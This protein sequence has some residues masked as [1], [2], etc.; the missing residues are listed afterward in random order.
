MKDH[1]KVRCEASGNYTENWIQGFPWV[2]QQILKLL[3]ERWWW[4][5]LLAKQQKK[6]LYSASLSKK[7]ITGIGIFRKVALLKISGNFLLIRAVD[8]HSAGCSV[9]KNVS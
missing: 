6:F 1:M 4:N 3:E 2:F 5:Q 8:L 9:T 7:S